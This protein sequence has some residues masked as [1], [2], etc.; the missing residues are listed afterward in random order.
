MIAALFESRRVLGVHDHVL[1]D[2]ANCLPVF[3]RISLLPHVLGNELV[4]AGNL[5]HQQS[6][7]GHLVV[8]Y[9]DPERPVGTRRTA[10]VS[11]DG[12]PSRKATANARRR[13]RSE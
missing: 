2:V 11:P 13:R 6:Q 8:V 7:V 1:V 4:A 9:G 3:A 5:I 12:L 10:T